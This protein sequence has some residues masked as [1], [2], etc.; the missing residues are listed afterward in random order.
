MVA[1]LAYGAVAVATAVALPELLPAGLLLTPRAAGIAA[2]G[3]VLLA[4]ALMQEVMARREAIGDLRGR[5]MSLGDYAARLREET[6]QIRDIQRATAANL[7]PDQSAEVEKLNG[8]VASLQSQIAELANQLAASQDQITDLQR[9]KALKGPLAPRPRDGGTT[10]EDDLDDDAVLDVLRDSINSDQME[11][12]IQPVVSLPQ[13]RLEFYECVPRLKMDRDLHIGPDRYQE[14]AEQE[15]LVASLENMLLVRAVQ[16]VRRARRR[17]QGVTYFCTV[18]AA[19]LK[20]RDLFADFVVF[21]HE[22]ADLAGHLSFA[23]SQHDFY[24]LDPRA[25]A[26]L[27]KLAKLGFRFML[28]RTTNLDL[29]VSDLSQ[30]GFR[31]VK[32]DAKL[33]LEKLGKSGDPRSLKR[34]LDPGAIDLVAANIDGEPM[35]LDVLDYAVDFGQGRLFGE[36]RPAELR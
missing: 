1:P 28:D 3:V 35:L 22:N 14:L 32:V 13:R 23:I 24:R 5:L 15:G 12:Y 26:E 34:Q 19:T 8:E 17:P 21:M 4:G 33:L 11:L 6:R 20:D 36:A 25:D 10:P 31:F 18:S 30:K 16:F 29:F 7:P 27:T 2:G 9:R